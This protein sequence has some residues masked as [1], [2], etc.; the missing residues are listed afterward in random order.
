MAYPRGGTYKY[1][2]TSTGMAM[3]RKMNV[4]AAAGVARGKILAS[5][6]G[7]VRTGGFYGRFSRGRRTSFSAQAELKFLDTTLAPTNVPQA[8]VVHPTVVA[9]PQ[10]ATESGRNGRKIVIKSLWFKGQ[11]QLTSQ[12]AT[13]NTDDTIRIIVV[14]DKQANGA[15]FTVGQVLTTADY[16]SFRN[17]ENERRFRILSDTTS[18]INQNG[19]LAAASFE[20]A[21]KFEKYIKCNI[22]MEYDATAASGVVGTMRSNNIAVIAIGE[23]GLAGFTYICRVRYSDT[24]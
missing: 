16:R 5:Q 12:A 7:Y 11:M 24:S 18:V 15:A 14:Q 3:V 10:D 8:G 23:A 13:G 2:P 22:P 17:L 21:R 4:V 9:V 20:Q 6:R 19:G 1:R